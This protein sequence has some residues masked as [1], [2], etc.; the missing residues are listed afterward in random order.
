MALPKDKEQDGQN[1]KLQSWRVES[2]C[3]ANW[4]RI[5]EHRAG[6][7]PRIKALT[8]PYSNNEVER[9]KS[10]NSFHWSNYH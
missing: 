5:A 9:N 2:V 3:E 8:F 4:G 1:P 10:Y 6:S 7:T